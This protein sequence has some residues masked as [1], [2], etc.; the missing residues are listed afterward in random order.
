MSLHLRIVLALAWQDGRLASELSKLQGKHH[1]SLGPWANPCR[2]PLSCSMRSCILD[3]WLTLKPHEAAVQGAA[4]VQYTWHD[5][6]F[7]WEF[8]FAHELLKDM[9]MPALLLAV[10]GKNS[11]SMTWNMQV[12]R[13]CLV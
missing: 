11:S 12:K 6:Q 4:I 10:A 3:F 8:E 9:G 7:S 2:R 5:D 1:A 13:P